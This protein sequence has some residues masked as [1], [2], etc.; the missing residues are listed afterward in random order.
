MK[1]EYLDS[2]YHDLDLQMQWLQSHKKRQ[3]LANDI[4]QLEKNLSQFSN[5]GQLV[6]EK[7]NRRFVVLSCSRLLVYYR[8]TDKN[9]IRVERL[10]KTKL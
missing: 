4:T 5:L 1:L 7:H 3:Q 6:S 9:L 10:V 8:I 2:F